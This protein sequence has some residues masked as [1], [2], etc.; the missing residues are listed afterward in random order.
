MPR[1][2]RC[3]PLCALF[4]AGIGRGY[5]T[6]PFRALLEAFGGAKWGPRRSPA[7]RQGEL[8]RRGKRGWPGPVRWGEAE[9]RN[10][11]VFALL[12]GNEGYE[13]SDDEKQDKQ[14][15]PPPALSLPHICP[16][17]G[18]FQGF[19]TALKVKPKSVKIPM[20]GATERETPVFSAFFVAPAGIGGAYGHG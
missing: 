17:C 11:R 8:P 19:P 4:E 15:T 7:K 2:S 9:L 16:Q 20:A 18:Q 10:E 3:G 14:L 5:L 12:G 13:A 1:I 6:S